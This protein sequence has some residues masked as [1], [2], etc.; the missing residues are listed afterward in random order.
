MRG[1]YT[2][3]IDRSFF[4]SP[5]T[6]ASFRDWLNW[7]WCVCWIRYVGLGLD[8]F[9]LAIVF[10]VSW[11]VIQ[12]CFEQTMSAKDEGPRNCERRP[13]YGGGANTW[14]L[15]SRLCFLI[16]RNRPGPGVTRRVNG[17][18]W[19]QGD[20]PSGLR[21][22]PH[23]SFL[24]LTWSRPLSAEFLA[25]HMPR[26]CYQFEQK[27]KTVI[28]GYHCALTSWIM[29]RARDKTLVGDLSVCE[30]HVLVA[31]MILNNNPM[32]FHKN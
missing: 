27:A 25:S 21:I 7:D 32:C 12:K 3:R 10:S 28:L 14:C 17:H 15:E 22:C 16:P 20:P 5:S 24:R 29:P 23:L 18:N 11:Y 6:N 4:V 1:W 26:F 2:Q 19:S 13:E 8:S 31:S 30:D 9:T